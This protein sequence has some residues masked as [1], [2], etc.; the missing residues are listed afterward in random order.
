MNLSI[1]GRKRKMNREIKFRAWEKEEKKMILPKNVTDNIN[2][3]AR[4]CLSSNIELMQYTGIKDKNGTE[5]Y[6]GDILELYDEEDF[7]K[8]EYQAEDVRFLLT[9]NS[10][11]VSFEYYSQGEIEVVGNIY[12]NSKLLQKIIE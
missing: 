10:I 12:E 2:I 4:G 9:S 11:C 3:F 8:V 6:E 1:T 7:F 5:I